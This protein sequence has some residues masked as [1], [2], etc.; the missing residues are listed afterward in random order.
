MYLYL[1]RY[2]ATQRKAVIGECSAIMRE[3]ENQVSDEN[4]K[5]EFIKVK[6]QLDYFTI[7]P[8]WRLLSMQ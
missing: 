5:N 6:M 3:Y 7:R 2:S 1:R 4:R 8:I